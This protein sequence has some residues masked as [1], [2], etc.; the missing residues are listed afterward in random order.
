M[1]NIQLLKYS[2][3]SS[4]LYCDKSCL[5]FSELHQLERGGAYTWLVKINAMVHIRLKIVFD[6]TTLT[7]MGLH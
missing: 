6:V 3:H 2:S 5:L 4:L 1:W 7:T